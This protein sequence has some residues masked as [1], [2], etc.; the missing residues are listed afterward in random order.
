MMEGRRAEYDRVV[1]PIVG[2]VQRGLIAQFGIE[3]GGDVAAEVVAWAWEHI[4]RLSDVQNP[5]GFLFRVGQSAARRHRRWERDR[6]R[7]PARPEWVE[8]NAPELDDEVIEAMRL[9]KASQRV[10]VLLVHGYGF[11]Y[12]EVAD[13]MQLSEPAVTNHIHRGLIRLRYLLKEKP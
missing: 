13:L 10:A 7:F 6:A 12:R 11:T 5:A 3:V 8:A 1:S 4:E 9:L 2:R